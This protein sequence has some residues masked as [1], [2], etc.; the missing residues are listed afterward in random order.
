MKRRAAA[1]LLAA[2]MVLTLCGASVLAAEENKEGGNPES[3]EEVPVTDPV[4]SLTFANLDRRLRE[5][6]R[7]HV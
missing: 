6:G 5:I 7:A 4:G 3:G 2:A 1:L